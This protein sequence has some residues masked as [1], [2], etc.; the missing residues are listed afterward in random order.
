MDDAPRLARPQSRPHAVASGAL[1]GAAPL[2]AMLLARSPAPPFAVPFP[3]AAPALAVVT[4]VAL[5]VAA[6]TWPR[7]ETAGRAAVTVALAGAAMLLLP[8]AMASPFLALVLLLAA[9][10]ALASIW[11]LTGAF[12]RRVSADALV[13]GRARGASLAALAGWAVSSTL[14][15]GATPLE[16]TAVRVSLL[17]AAALVLFWAFGARGVARSRLLAIALAAVAAGLAVLLRRETEGGVILVA[18]SAAA[19]PRARRGPIDWEVWWEPLLG[20]PQRLVVGTF[21]ALIVAGTFLLALPAL[22]S[23]G[24]GL[25]PLDAAFTAVSAVCVTGL[26]VVDT[27]TAFTVPGQVLIL[28]LIQLG[29]LG[30]MTYSTVLLQALGRRISLRHEGAV[31]RLLSSQDRG[32]LFEATRRVLLFTFACEAL[33]AI[34]LFAG[35]LAAGDAAGSAAWRA[36]FTSVSAFCNAGFALDTES[37]IAVADQP[38]ILHTV[39]LLIILGGLSPAVVLVVPRWFRRGT[40]PVPL[41]ARLTVTAAGALLAVAFVFFAAVEWT[42]ALG[43]LPAVDRLHH[44]W[45][46]SVTLRTAGFNSVDLSAVNASTLSLMMAWM[47]IGGSP[48]GTAGGIKTTTVALLILSVVQTVRGRARVTVAGRSIPE[49]SLRQAG[50]VVTLAAAFVGL[51]IVALQLTQDMPA[52]LAVFEAV[53]AFGTVGLSIGGTALLDGPGK[54]IVMVGMFVGRVGTLTLLMFLAQRENAPVLRRPEEDVDVG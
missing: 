52:R 15:G 17:L 37:L 5:I 49:A 1:L 8:A 30:I 35:F 43:H 39:A 46:Q 7:N 41:Q 48:G 31:A 6:L 50:V 9:T 4:A 16:E 13:P 11:N 12:P 22:S 26:I 34:A 21:A 38:G 14:P 23:D 51:L 54:V 45:F 42:G 33:G 25:A 10:A 36:V 24:A 3:G 19:I 20:N 29:G 40:R 44:A 32:R 47:F 53:S 27:A 2:T 18:V 28:I